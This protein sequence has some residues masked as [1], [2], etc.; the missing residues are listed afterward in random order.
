[1][2]GVGIGLL[3]YLVK[4]LLLEAV[5][6]DDVLDYDVQVSVEISQLIDPVS[7]CD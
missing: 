1:M 5:L 7:V 3:D 2:H 6:L 4:G